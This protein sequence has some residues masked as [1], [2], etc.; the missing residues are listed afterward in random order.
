MLDANGVP[1]YTEL[2][3]KNPDGLSIVNAIARYAPAGFAPRLVN[4]Q[5]YWNEIMLYDQQSWCT[6][7]QAPRTWISK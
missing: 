6:P 7:A 2:I 1:H 5:Y 3:T 4:D